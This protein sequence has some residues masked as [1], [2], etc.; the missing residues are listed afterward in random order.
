M[1]ATLAGSI[2]AYIETLGLNVAVFN[3]RPKPGTRMPYVLVSDGVSVNPEPAFPQ[4]D[5]PE[6][7]VFELVSVDLWEP[8]DPENDVKESYTLPDALTLGLRGAHLPSTGANKPPFPVSGKLRVFSGP[9]RLPDQAG[10]TMHTNITLRV[11]RQ[12][13]HVA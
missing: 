12:L 9:T 13:L 10:K 3:R 11:D 7:H 8:W 4:H 5:D 1:S 2:K 6:G